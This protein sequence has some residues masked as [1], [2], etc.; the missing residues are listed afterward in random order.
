[1]YYTLAK[2]KQFLFSPWFNLTNI[3]AFS[4]AIAA[5]IF[6][7]PYFIW[8]AKHYYYIFT[9]S[10]MCFVSFLFF[11]TNQLNYKYDTII[12][13]LCLFLLYITVLPTMDES[14]NKWI[15]LCPFV[16]VFF[17][18][19]DYLQ[20]KI[21]YL[22]GNI[23]LISLI[24]GLIISGLLALGIQI[25]FTK[26][27]HPFA[28]PSDQ[29][30][31][32]SFPG[33]LFIQGNVWA[34]PNGGILGRLCGIWDEP[35]VVGTTSALLLAA[36][37]F[38]LSTLKNKLL[39]LAGLLSFSLAFLT[40][41]AL[42][43]SLFAI[44]RKKFFL[45]ICTFSCVFTLLFLLGKIHLPS[46]AIKCDL[47]LMPSSSLSQYKQPRDLPSKSIHTYIVTENNLI[48]ANKENNNF[49]PINIDNAKLDTIKKKLNITLPKSNENF[50]L[51]SPLEDEKVKK[52][53]HLSG[54]IFTTFGPKDVS[55]KNEVMT[56]NSA[57]RGSK[58][59][60]RTTPAMEKLFQQYSTSS[61]N[62]VLFGIASDASYLS[63]ASVWK[64]I[65][66]DYG[67]VGLFLLLSTFAYYAFLNVNKQ[68]FLF[69]A[70]FMLVFFLSF[71]QRPGIWMPVFLI[72][73]AGGILIQKDEV[74]LTKPSQEKKSA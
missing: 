50:K 49:V 13:L 46:T 12:V 62:V 30:F 24:P 6:M 4:V 26:I 59:N 55:I 40:L 20:K 10:G 8:P 9:I 1:M 56:L 14:H 47:L 16:I 52:I 34:L 60:N 72:I 5:L 36:T 33:V 25:P 7:Q 66:T 32:L 53:T 71:Y 22:F 68:N 19:P 21:F 73:F 67:L 37:G 28:K 15:I 45:L 64:T 2:F 61:L 54:K 51:I 23:F 27:A 48:Y 18:L 39:A 74:F 17:S 3:L 70:T 65:L 58:F 42:G 29:I 38:N 35:G 69:I 11:R 44:L 31:Y 43:T 63:G 57:L 41:V